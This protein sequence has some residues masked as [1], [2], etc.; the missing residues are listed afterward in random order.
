L[1]FCTWSVPACVRAP[2]PA[3]LFACWWCGCAAGALLLLPPPAVTFCCALAVCAPLS[4]CL[5]ACRW[6]WRAELFVPLPG[7]GRWRASVARGCCWLWRASAVLCACIHAPV[8]PQAHALTGLPI[9]RACA[10]Q[11]HH[12]GSRSMV[13]FA[14]TATRAPRRTLTLLF[15]NPHTPARQQ[16]PYCAL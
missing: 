9:H 2:L 11:P 10:L 13:A 14:W 6:C 7:S 15:S 16:A 12:P 5:A 1:G 8:V 4:P 3:Q